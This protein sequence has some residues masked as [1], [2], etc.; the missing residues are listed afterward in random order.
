VS[1]PQKK[2]D[3]AFT[4]EEDNRLAQA[5]APEFLA[6]ESDVIMGND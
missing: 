2:N 3:T 4:T 6:V 1:R 5:A